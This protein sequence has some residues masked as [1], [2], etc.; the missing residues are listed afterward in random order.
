MGTF[1]ALL[2]QLGIDVG[3]KPPLFTIKDIALAQHVA[4]LLAKANNKS[5]IQW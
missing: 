3:P 4:K 2:G 5:N 1:Q